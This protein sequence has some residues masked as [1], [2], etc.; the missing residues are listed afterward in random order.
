MLFPL[1]FLEVLDL[2]Q[3]CYS[4]TLFYNK[5]H[6]TIQRGSVLSVVL[7]VL[8]VA[9]ATMLLIPVNIL[10]NRFCPF[11]IGKKKKRTNTL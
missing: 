6:I 7:A 8:S 11:L 5:L 2:N 4:F 3:R 1:F 10:L 9:I